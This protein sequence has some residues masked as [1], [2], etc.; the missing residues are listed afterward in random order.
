M[1]SQDWKAS[2]TRPH[3]IK[4]KW[5]SPILAANWCEVLWSSVV[6]PML[7]QTKSM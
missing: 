2:Y 7:N 5:H 3:F 6:G 1:L 4:D